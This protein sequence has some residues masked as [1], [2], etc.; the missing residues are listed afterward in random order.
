MR[1]SR[2]LAGGAGRNITIFG[3]N[4]Q[5]AE[6]HQEFRQR[7]HFPFPLLEDEGQKVAKLYNSDGGIVN[8]TVYLIG[9]DGKI[10]YARRGMPRPEEVLA[11]VRNEQLAISS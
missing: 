5:S 8:R 2:C 4:P 3:I 7:N 11:A 10:R 6:S 1:V 9:P